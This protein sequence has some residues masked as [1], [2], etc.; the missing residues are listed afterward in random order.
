MRIILQPASDP[1]LS[2]WPLFTD[3]NK[4][5]CHVCHRVTHFQLTSFPIHLFSISIW[6]RTEWWHQCCCSFLPSLPPI[7]WSIL[8]ATGIIRICIKHIIHRTTTLLTMPDG[9]HIIGEPFQWKAWAWVAW[10]L[11]MIQF[12]VNKSLPY[13]NL[14]WYHFYLESN[15]QRQKIDT[16]E[17]KEADERG[18][19][20][21]KDDERKCEIFGVTSSNSHF[22]KWEKSFEKFFVTIY[23]P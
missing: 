11:V 16:I 12:T 8:G 1:V 21:A 18:K 4:I 5:N 13:H 20:W 19:K 22:N 9:V 6:L 15:G 17:E 3:S 7:N 23:F 14:P 2:K 10:F